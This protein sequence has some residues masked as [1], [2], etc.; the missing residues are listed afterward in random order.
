M[1]LGYGATPLPGLT[2]AITI[3]GNVT[4]AEYEAARLQQAVELITKSLQV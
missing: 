3:E 4:L 2:E 1:L